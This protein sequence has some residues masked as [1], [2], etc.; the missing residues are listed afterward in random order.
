MQAD[1]QQRADH[2]IQLGPPKGVLTGETKEAWAEKQ[3]KEICAKFGYEGET[4]EVQEKRTKKIRTKSTY[5]PWGDESD[6]EDE[7][8]QRDALLAREI[9]KQEEKKLD[10]VEQAARWDRERAK[11]EEEHQAEYLRARD[12]LARTH[13]EQWAKEKKELDLLKVEEL[14][15][16]KAQARALA[17]MREAEQCKLGMAAMLEQKNDLYERLKKRVDEKKKLESLESLAQA[18]QSLVVEGEG[19]G[20]ST[21]EVTMETGDEDHEMDMTIVEQGKLPEA[22]GPAEQLVYE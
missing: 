6:S 2:P 8:M 12:E 1:K 13:L 9:S 18:V 10:E 19:K 20:E 3:A 17:K 14:R 15:L 5:H 22:N 4:K 16:Q 21:V 11:E 7:S